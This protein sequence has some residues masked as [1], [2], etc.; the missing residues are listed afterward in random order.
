[1]GFACRVAGHDQ[2]LLKEKQATRARDALAAE[3]RRLPM[4]RVGKITCLKLPNTVY[5]LAE[6]SNWPSIERDGLLSASKLLDAAG[7][8]RADRVRLERAQ[9]LAHTELP[10]GRKSETSGRCRPERSKLAWSA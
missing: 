2:F 10:T 3:R 9:R 5:H 8:A 6:E 7:L 4:V 1:V